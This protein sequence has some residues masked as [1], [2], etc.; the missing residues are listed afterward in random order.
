MPP[1]DLQNRRFSEVNSETVEAIGKCPPL[2]SLYVPFSVSFLLYKPDYRKMHPKSVE[3]REAQDMVK[4]R[5]IDTSSQAHISR[6][7]PMCA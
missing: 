5:N 2:L 7:G 1:F 3:Q 6:K 4:Q